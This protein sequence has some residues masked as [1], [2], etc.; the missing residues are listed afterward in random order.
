VAF[1][2]RRVLNEPHFIFGLCELNRQF[3]LQSSEPPSTNFAV[4][5]DGSDAWVDFGHCHNCTDHI[6]E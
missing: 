1:K 2:Q 5:S 6:L 3:S 4:L